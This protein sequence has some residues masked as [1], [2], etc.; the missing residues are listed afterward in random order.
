MQDLFYESPFFSV[1]ITTFNRA[2]LLK[3][4]INSLLLQTETNWEA[5]IIDDGSTDKT[6]EAL[7]EFSLENEKIKVFRFDN[8]GPNIA[9]NRG[10]KLASSNFITFLDS[11][12]EYKNNHLAIRKAMFIKYPELK[13]IHGGIEIIGDEYVPDRYDTN[14]KIHLSECVIGGTFFIQKDVFKQIGYF[15]DIAMGSDA[16]F[17][18]RV[19]QADLESTKIDTPTYIY[20]REHEDSVTKNIHESE[21]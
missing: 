13:F 7:K 8:A 9:K 2:N 18:D 12:D 15:K 3:R 21:S 11:D 1:V 20:H 16:D 5:I 10:I 19:C 14:Q 6:P 4:A 17:Y